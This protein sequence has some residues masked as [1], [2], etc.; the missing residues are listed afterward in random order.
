MPITPRTRLAVRA[1][2]ALLPWSWFILR[3][4]AVEFDAAAI[5]L[6]LLWLAALAIVIP[7]AGY[8]RSIAV[9]LLSLS[10][11][12]VGPA[13]IVGPWLPQGGESPSDG[14]RVVAANVAGLPVRFLDPSE[15]IW[16]GGPDV[17]VLTELDRNVAFGLEE[18]YEYAMTAQ[19]R[20]GVWVFSRWPLSRV[21]SAPEAVLRFGLAVEVHGP[22]QEFLLYALHLPRPWP[23]T[24]ELHNSSLR[25][26][27][28]L[29]D[30]LVEAVRTEKRPV[31]IAGDLNLSDRTTGYRALTSETKDAMRTSWT[32]PTSIRWS[33]LL[34][35]ID[36]I[37]VPT[38]WCAAES[39]HF[40]IAG[41]DHH[42]ISSLI[43]R[44]DGA[45]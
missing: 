4:L 29:I 1:A 35:R 28:S 21:E 39:R 27:R 3:D 38:N 37:L 16:A 41:S 6:P 7:I 14:L 31:V 22:Q 44:C 10:L 34:L 25:D 23:T 45:G 5:G 26:H 9:G 17:L 40:Q 43:G 15:E 33:A 36:H 13:A 42:G 18:T 12:V 32:Q 11:A 20:S 2:A 19:G 8:R 30:S 24:S